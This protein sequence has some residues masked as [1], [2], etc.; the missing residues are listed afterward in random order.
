EATG[1]ARKTTVSA[2]SSRFAQSFKPLF[3]CD[4]RAHGVTYHPF[5]PFLSGAKLGGKLV[6]LWVFLRAD[7][8]R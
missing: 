5:Y 2:I 1:E 8:P 7:L 4:C 3:E 6:G